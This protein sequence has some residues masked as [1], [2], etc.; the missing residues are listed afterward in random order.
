[1]LPSNEFIL[2][3]CLYTKTE[4]KGIYF[5]ANSFV[6]HSVTVSHNFYRS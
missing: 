6:R 2:S 5:L 1:M 4:T 3:I